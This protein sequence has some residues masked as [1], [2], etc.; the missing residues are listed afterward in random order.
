MCSF[1]ED[2]LIP[3]IPDEEPEAVVSS[4]GYIEDYN[5]NL[6]NI[7]TMWKHTKGKGVKV[8]ILDTGMPQ[9]KDVP[10]TGSQTFIP[11][12]LKDSNGHSTGVGALIGGRYPKGTL[13]I[14]GVAPECELY[15]GA[16]LNASGAGSLSAI[17]KGIRWAVDEVGANVIN[18][19][20]GTPHLY[21]CD[22][23]VREACQYAYDKGVTLVAAAGNDASD[24]NWPAAINTVIAV[25][26]VDRNLKTASFSARGPEVEFAA[27]GVDVMTAYK[28]GGYA[29]VSGTSFSAPVISGIVALILSE[30]LSRGK[31][32]DPEQVRQ[33]LK[34]IAYD[35]GEEGKDNE[36]GWGIPVFTKDT[37]NAMGKPGKPKVGSWLSRVLKSLKW[38]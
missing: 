25:A 6:T 32:L 7:P 9:H 4:L 10:V 21:G 24:V 22:P 17:A 37:E 20:L 11:G 36:T 26:A 29:T 34:D 14:S 19:S 16:V 38:W 30:H 35:I 1:K 28:G 31:L 33:H 12:Y 5:H 23:R 8:A 13:G 3:M 27:G 18:M 2:E 15:F